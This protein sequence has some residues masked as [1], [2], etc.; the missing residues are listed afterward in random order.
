M[1]DNSKASEPNDST[2][3]SDNRVPAPTEKE[4]WKPH[5]GTPN[6]PAVP[7]F[8]RPT[9]RYTALAVPASLL[10]A[11]TQTSE[12]G[13]GNLLGTVVGGLAEAGGA[14]LT[15]QPLLSVAVI[16]GLVGAGYTKMRKDFDLTRED[17]GFA[18]RRELRANLSRRQLVKKRRTLRPSLA[19]VPGRS[20]PTNAV[21]IYIGKCRKTGLHLY[22]SIEES[23]LMLAPMGAGKT[24]KIANW[25]IDAEG[26]VLATSTKF[27]VVEWTE[28]LRSRVG[29]VLVWNPQ[30][31]ATRASDIAWDPVIGCADPEL[32]VE[33]SMRRA[34]YLLDGSDATAGLENRSFWESA[35]YSVLKAFL[36]AA[37]AADLSLL[38]VA[39]W[40]KSVANTEAIKIFEKFEQP[41]PRNPHRPVA[42]RGWKADLMQVQMVKGK[43]TTSENVFGTLA[44]T[45]MFLDAPRVQ[46]IIEKAHQVDQ[47]DISGYLRSQDTLYLL[48]RDDGRGSVGPLFTAFTGELYEAA[49]ALAPMNPG[50]RLDPPWTMV[51]DEAALICSV[52]LERWTADSRGLGISIH[53]VFQSPAQ[54]ME[55]WG[56]YGYQTIWDNCV[57]LVLGG[58]SNEDHLEGLSRLCGKHYVKR[59]SRSTNPG[60]DGTMRASVSHTQVEVET[61]T[62]SQIMNLEP[63]QIL[64]LRKHLGGPVVVKFTPVWKRKDIKETEKADKKAAKEV[65]KAR[66][67]KESAAAVPPLSAPADVWGPPRQEDP[68]APAEPETSP[69]TA[70][71][72]AS[73]WTSAP[74]GRHLRVA[75]SE[76]APPLS[77]GA[78]QPPVVVP[79]K[80]GYAP[81]EHLEQVPPQPEPKEDLIEPTRLSKTGTDA[82]DPYAAFND[83]DDPWG[84]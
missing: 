19:D 16:G 70:D 41:D 82:A 25:I 46:R 74:A 34:K 36:W 84:R 4:A 68:W 9:V 32:G 75:G 20:V 67:R 50:G 76:D 35:S 27:D 42:P 7:V 80:P 57:K 58:L 37:D 17:D 45:F 78:G 38:D 81:T 33:R 73:A 65:L 63:G 18:R 43:P 29:R 59:E 26:P 62:P 66:R 51:L 71:P 5:Q 23:S 28:R 79:P 60:P 53:A 83:D 72:A 8:G 24:A 10:A 44:K 2:T 39:R 48:G 64:V 15:E 47:F 54:I 77:P 3:L 40:S 6:T 49:R 30:G 56:R 61:M 52:P 21:G 31:I 22:M 1:S 11:E 13:S 14:L 69:W 55:R 12:D